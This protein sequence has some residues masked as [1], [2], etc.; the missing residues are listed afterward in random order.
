MSAAS[1]EAVLR[2]ADL[3]VVLDG[4]VTLEDV[5]FRVERGEV[6]TI[7]GPNGA[8]KTVLLRTL[9]GRLRH[10]GTVE[11]APGIRIGYV[12]QRPPALRDMPLSIADFFSLKHG[13]P[14]D[15]ARALETVGLRR[16]SR[17][18][19]G[20]LSAG[21]LQRVLIA[22]ALVGEPD[23]LLFDEPTTGL[24]LGGE[25]TI[26]GLL[27]RLSGERR[28]TMLIVTHDLAAVHRLST[29]VLCLH[30]RLLCHGPP[31]DVLTPAGLERLF[32]PEVKYYAH[33][34]GGAS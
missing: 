30:R 26:Y 14:I 18:R 10:A 34:H 1:T 5:S 20:D 25:E 9:L 31:L 21:Q 4:R 22:W 23:V 3:R 29:S 7:L 13:P 24:D 17:D 11:W 12:P 27:S 28:L 2:V 19:V 8:G 16:D 32:G 33:A 15:V 6:V